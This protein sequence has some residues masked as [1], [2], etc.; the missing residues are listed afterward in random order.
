[1]GRPIAS[2]HNPPMHAR[3]ADRPPRAR[4]FPAPA[5]VLVACLLVTV[6]CGPLVPQPTAS[7][8]ASSSPALPTAPSA[9]ISASPAGSASPPTDAA[10]VYATI[11]QQVIAL[12]GL[13][14]KSTIE[15]QT[16]ND[17]Q[18][19]ARIEATFKLDNPPDVVAA[20]ERLLKGLG[21]FPKDASL[22]ALYVELLSSQVKGLYSP[23]DK[24][25][26]VVSN[27][28]GVGPLE[29]WTFSH[30]F[31]HGLQDQNFD[32]QSLELNAV[33]EGDRGLARLSLVEGDATAVMTQWAQKNLT[34]DELVQILRASLDPEALKILE[35]MPPI[36]RE[37]L[38]FPYDNGLRFVMGLQQRGGWKV[39][40]AAFAK[41][42]ASS[43]QILHPEKYDAAEAPVAIDVPK[44]LDTRMGDGW[45]VGLQ[46]TLGEF[47]LGIWLR[48]GLIRVPLATAAAAGWGG[49]RVTLLDGPNGSWAIALMTAWDTAADAAEFADGAGQTLTALGTP[50]TVNAPP[51]S[52]NVT[53]LLGSDA[54]VATTLDTIAG[55]TGT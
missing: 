49:D 20:N 5:A 7:S 53:V 2:C 44:D 1:M 22:S 34:P 25:L 26:F 21:L 10:T 50:G 6:G 30:E 31:T 47:Q 33:G 9:S 27:S 19:K 8:T 38:G 28:A 12:R 54:T 14:P 52:K 41:P 48:L 15:P 42:P 40:D 29:R 13:Q 39:V 37:P 32:L 11:E 51:G 43:E 4:R 18:L 35:K 16:L 45:K 24:Q 46:D 55:G 23:T 17:Q 3:R 36:L